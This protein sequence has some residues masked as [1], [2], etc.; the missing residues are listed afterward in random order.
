[1]DAEM[2]MRMDKERREGETDKMVVKPYHQD[3]VRMHDHQ[4]F[5]LAYITG[6]SAEHNL[7]GETGRVQKGDYFIIDYGS[8]HCYQNSCDC[9]LIN[10][11]FLPELVD[12][13]LAECRVFDELLR[14]CLIRYYKHY[15]GQTPVNR[16]FHDEDGRIL[17]LVLQMQA[18]YE[19]KDMGYAEIL[20]NKLLEI[21]ILTM[22]KIMK[23]QIQEY[24]KRAES[25]AVQD[26]IRYLKKHYRD[27]AV[28]S[29]YCEEAHYS[30]QYISRRFKQET[31]LTA[32]QY[33]QK[34]RIEKCCELLRGSNLTI[35][36]IAHETGYD[37]M[38]FFHKIF[39]RMLHMSPG[40]YRKLM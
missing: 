14:V 8:L 17:A 32:L 5:E 15:Y 25:T 23:E 28:I 34:L 16:I 37:D 36:E 18:E 31:G 11:L 24:S 38:K 7:N 2:T 9:T 3:D 19:Q 22:R 21:L 29:R 39:R 4:F 13:T 20:R 1:M 35:Q 40:E 26:A 30:P 10:C 12:E 27:K 6:G 33:L